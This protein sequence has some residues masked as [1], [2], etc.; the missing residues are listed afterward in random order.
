MKILIAEDDKD[1]ALSYKRV[2]ERPIFASAYIRDFIG[3]CESAKPIRNS[4]WNSGQLDMYF[5]LDGYI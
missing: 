1:T 5:M 2:L 4:R 3:F